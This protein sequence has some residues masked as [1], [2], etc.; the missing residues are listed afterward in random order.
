MKSEFILESN[1][2][3]ERNDVERYFLRTYFDQQDAF[4]AMLNY[5]MKEHAY[6]RLM[7]A[8]TLGNLDLVKKAISQGESG[9][10]SHC[11]GDTPTMAAARM[12]HAECLDILIQDCSPFKK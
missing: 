6:S 10:A 1:A 12:G 3:P 9:D 4:H 7:K 5:S 2:R 8:A 11:F